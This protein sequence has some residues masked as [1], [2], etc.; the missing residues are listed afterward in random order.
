MTESSYS[1]V[2]ESVTLRRG[3]EKKRH[4]VGNDLSQLLLVELRLDGL[5]TDGSQSL[6]SL[7]ELA[8]LDEVTRR[9]GQTGDT[10][11]K[12]QS[13]GELDTDWYAVRA[14]IHAVL[15]TIDNARG[16]EKTNGDAELVAGDQGA[17]NLPRA[18]LR[19][20]KDDNGR[21]ETDTETSDEATG[22]EKRDAGGD[23]FHNDSD[24]E[25]EATD[26]DGGTTT[27][28]VGNVT[29]GEST[30]ILLEY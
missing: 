20:V 30:C 23:N 7:L 18:N 26:D 6:S 17:T 15:S 24:H 29:S 10:T 9:L 27:N 11:T 2:Q 12:D 21:F 8:L 16:E 3:S 28:E 22:R 4:T 5:T 14:T 25:D 13:P 19:H 1:S